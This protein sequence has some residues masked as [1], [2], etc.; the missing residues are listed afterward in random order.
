MIEKTTDN[1]KKILLIIG[2]S[3]LKQY[4]GPGFINLIKDYEQVYIIDPYRYFRRFNIPILFNIAKRKLKNKARSLVYRQPINMSEEWARKED[5]CKIVRKYSKCLSLD[6]RAIEFQSKDF[7]EA[8]KYLKVLNGAI[9]KDISPIYIN[10]IE[11]SSYL[12]D[13]LQRFVIGFSI[14]KNKSILSFL[15]AYLYI[16]NIIIYSRWIEEKSKYLDISDCL[17]NHYVYMESGYIST[18]LNKKLDIGIIH[19]NTRQLAAEYIQ[20]REKWFL[21]RLYLLNKQSANKVTDN[22][23]KIN[24]D[25]WNLDNSLS[26]LG[27]LRKCSINNRKILI[28]MHAFGDANSMHPDN[29]VIFGSYY[30]WIRKTLEIA[31]DSPT[32]SYEFRAHPASYTTYISDIG[33]IKEI[34][35]DLPSNIKII[36]PGKSSQKFD[37]DVPLI[38]TAKGNISQETATSGIKSICL[39]LPS[40]APGTF[41]L[42][43]SMDEYYYWLSGEADVKTLYLSDEEI[44]LA[45]RNVRNFLAI[46]KNYR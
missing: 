38:V 33:L 37:K 10:N 41:H 17:I 42:V 15:S 35:K 1:S 36:K 40:A 18:L 8:F 9:S 45:Q 16:Y 29:K 34:F 2:F 13:S 31:R 11:A 43:A 26:N 12:I 6:E 3:L 46:N 7:K 22:D 24:K 44:E 32:V 28:V 23:K 4:E 21:K 30:Q 39:D 20:P 27:D 19:L 25:I 5:I 14:H